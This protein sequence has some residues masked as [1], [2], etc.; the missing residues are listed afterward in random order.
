MENNPNER[1]IVPLTGAEL[2]SVLLNPKASEK[3]KTAALEHL[4]LA[5]EA[6]EADLSRW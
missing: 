4:R 3:E 5:V 2:V 1:P 6:L